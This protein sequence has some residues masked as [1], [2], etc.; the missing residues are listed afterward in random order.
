MTRPNTKAGGS[1]K[2]VGRGRPLSLA[3]SRQALLD[4]SEYVLQ[5]WLPDGTCSNQEYVAKNPTRD[6]KSPGSFKINMDTGVW[7]DFATEDAKGANLVDLYVYLHGITDKKVA[8][9]ELSAFVKEHG[10]LSSKKAPSQRKPK[11]EKAPTETIKKEDLHVLPPDCDCEGNFVTGEWEYRTP[12]GEILFLMQR[13]EPEPG[14]KKVFPVRY[15]PSQKKWVWSYP[16]GKLPLF[17]VDLI[18][19]GSKVLFAEGEK[20]ADHL[21]KLAGFISITSSGGSSR[22]LET[23]LQP[24]KQATAVQVFPDADAPGAK[25]AAQVLA[26][27]AIHSIPAR[28]LDTAAMGW[29][30]GQDAADFPKLTM[31]DYEPCLLNVEAWVKLSD[32]NR[33]LLDTAVFQVLATLPSVDYDRL[34]KD[35]AKLLGIGIRAL[36]AEVKK[37]KKTERVKPAGEVEEEGDS[38]E[39]IEAKREELYPDIKH[40]AEAPDILKLVRGTVRLMGIVGEDENTNL[41][42]LGIT[43]RFLPKPVNVIVKG[44]SGSGKSYVTQSTIRLFPGIAFYM[45]TGGSSKSLVHTDEDFSHRILVIL[46][47]TQLNGAKDDDPY[48]MFL[49]T[50]ISEG[51]IRYEVV[52]K[53]PETKRMITRVAVKEGPT[54]VMLT[55]TADAIHHENETRMLSAYSNETEDQTKAIMARVAQ[56]FTEP[57][58]EEQVERAL[59]L[60]HKFHEW[61]ARSNHKVVIPFMPQVVAAIT[62]TPVRFRRDV[63]QL[64]SLIQTSTIIHQATRETNSDGY[65]VAT[66]EDYQTARGV[67]LQSLQVSTDEALAPREKLILQAIYDAMPEAAKTGKEA[68]RVSSRKIARAAGI[69][70]TTVSYQIKKAISQGVLENRE[71]QLG[72]PMRLKFGS[73]FSLSMLEDSSEVLPLPEKLSTENKESL[74]LYPEKGCSAAHFAPQPPVLKGLGVS[75]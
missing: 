6:D 62:H 34:K 72:K 29:S 46:E 44:S 65:L 15:V 20:T 21:S 63:S 30:G 23:D 55:T 18:V 27:C 42:Y 4:N 37:Y 54:G 13:T 14:K 71:M 25:Y 39:E 69:P 2:P 19:D 38:P 17:N 56:T 52:E 70:Q 48:S 8:A 7:S 53:D 33:E 24:L 45:L 35:T 74:S 10:L 31:A 57:G 32:G 59:E 43:S 22:L 28:I 50:L 64:G 9:R 68:Y 5:Q 11:K 51:Y 58:V 40:I 61:L 67:I 12:E 75:E 3:R 16:E 66:L 26:Y 36:D 47:A 49:R 41:T 1:G 73:D 60:W